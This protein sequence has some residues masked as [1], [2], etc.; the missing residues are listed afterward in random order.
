MTDPLI[1]FLVGFALGALGT[2]VGA[3]AYYIQMMEERDD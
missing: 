3:L 1:A 2:I